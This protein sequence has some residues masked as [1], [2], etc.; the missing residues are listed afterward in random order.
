[1]KNKELLDLMPSAAKELRE[2]KSFISL[3]TNPGHNTR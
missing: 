2:W 1:M 3:V